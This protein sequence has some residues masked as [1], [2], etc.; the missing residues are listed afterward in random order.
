VTTKTDPIA[1]FEGV[2]AILAHAETPLV[3]LED[4][5]LELQRV[6]GSCEADLEEIASRRKIEAT[7]ATPAG[8]MDKKLDTLDRRPTA[9]PSADGG[10]SRPIF[11]RAIIST[12]ADQQ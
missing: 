12:S 11:G 5:V 10:S 9:S 4:G 6:M 3:K 1:H 2:Q 7:A 8:E